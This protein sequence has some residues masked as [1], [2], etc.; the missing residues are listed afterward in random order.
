[1]VFYI[2]YKCSYLE[3]PPWCIFAMAHHD[4]IVAQRVEGQARTPESQ[5]TLLQQLRQEPLLSQVETWRNSIEDFRSCRQPEHL[6]QLREFLAKLRLAPTIPAMLRQSTLRS[7]L[8][9]GGHI[10]MV[11]PLCHSYG[12]SP[13]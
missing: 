6:K 7:R 10:T 4:L 2:S 3:A 8:A 11:M 9:C 5:H 12:G 13:R 1:M